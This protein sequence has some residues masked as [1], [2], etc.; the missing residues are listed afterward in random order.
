MNVAKENCTLG[1][2]RRDPAD[3]L[4]GR[5]LHNIPSF[6]SIAVRFHLKIPANASPGKKLRLKGRGIPAKTPG[7]LYVVVEI[8]WPPADNKKAKKLYEQMSRS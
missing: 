5:R 6:G 1:V 2:G 8:A 4:R 3:V 7:D